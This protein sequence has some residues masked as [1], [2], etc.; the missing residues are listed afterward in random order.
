MYLF[1]DDLSLHKTF[2]WVLQADK[3]SGTCII[4]IYWRRAKT[5]VFRGKQSWVLQSCFV[6]H[7][8][9]TVIC[10]KEVFEPVN[11]YSSSQLERAYMEE[12]KA[13]VLLKGSCTTFSNSILR[14]C[15]SKPK[16]D[17]AYPQSGR[18]VLLHQAWLYL[19]IWDFFGIVTDSLVYHLPFPT[20]TLHWSPS[21]SVDIT[22]IFNCITR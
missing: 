12:W 16:A 8:D 20:L 2:M 13:N 17:R 9:F 4:I 19:S 14:L 7:K 1:K 22:G 11:W 10:N 21:K 5:W 6:F 15:C 18:A 3:P